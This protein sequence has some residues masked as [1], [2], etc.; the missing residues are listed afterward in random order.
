[1]PYTADLSAPLTTSEPGAT[2]PMTPCEISGARALVDLATG[3]APVR[4][5][6][7]ML[8]AEL[9]VGIANY[10]PFH[11]RHDFSQ[12]SVG[13][14]RALHADL[15]FDRIALRVDRV[16]TLSTLSRALREIGCLPRQRHEAALAGLARGLRGL[17]E[18][19]AERAIGALLD[20]LAALAPE[21]R[22]GPLSRLIRSLGHAPQSARPGCLESR[23]LALA[24]EAALPER[25]PLLVLCLR[26]LGIATLRSMSLARWLRLAEPLREADRAAVMAH[27]AHVTG[28]GQ[29]MSQWRP[30]REQLLD[31][32]L[33]ARRGM[34]MA[35]RHRAEVLRALAEELDCHFEDEEQG[36]NANPAHAGVTGAA[37]RSSMHDVWHDLFD[38]AV[39]LPP[40]EAVPV[41]GALARCLDGAPPTW[42]EQGWDRVRDC[43]AGYEPVDRVAL[44]I[45]LAQCEMP[46]ALLPAVW[47]ALM[48]LS[49]RLPDAMQSMVLSQLAGLLMGQAPDAELQARWM[50]LLSRVRKLPPPC[51]LAPL[52]G[53]AGTMGWL[54]GDAGAMLWP[55]LEAE[56]ATLG[57]DDRAPLLAE[58]ARVDRLPRGVWDSLFAQAR[59]FPSGLQAPLLAALASSGELVCRAPDPARRWLA[60]FRLTQALG[61]EQQ[62]DRCW[63]WPSRW[64]GCPPAPPGGPSH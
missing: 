31:A 21:R 57:P 5:H 20:T 42:A 43:A 15:R 49:E 26:H 30:E 59:D 58:C 48:T 62:V 24:L 51:R 52:H 34:V 56:L 19:M 23:A 28:F 55:A 14:H 47:Q 64:S 18:S 2:P 22:M 27:L 8:P 44:L 41:V 29:S 46:D 4:V 35:P 50:A 25:G 9:I 40:L 32:T 10:L 1:M 7:Q 6:L 45:A 13:M 33:R 17:H 12:A 3:A 36:E 16:V 63:N 39:G 11:A 53:A 60:V 38:L 37:G 54:H 61:A